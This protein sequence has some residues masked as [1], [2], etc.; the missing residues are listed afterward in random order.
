[1]MLSQWVNETL[2]WDFQIGTGLIEKMNA[3]FQKLTKKARGNTCDT[4]S[5]HHRFPVHIDRKIKIC[6]PFIAPCAGNGRVHKIFGGI[7]D[8]NKRTLAITVFLLLCVVCVAQAFFYYPRLPERVAHHFGAS[9]QPDAWGS[10]EHFLTVYLVVVGLM[11]VMFL[12]FAL[13][14]RKIPGSLMNLPNKQYWLAPERRRETLDYIGSQFLWLGSLTMLLL[15]D[16]FHQSFM[17]HLGK[18]P[19]LG[20]FWITIGVYL[21]LTVVWC[22]VFF[23]KFRKE[24]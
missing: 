6:Q 9:G 21:V 16:V 17:V 2:L 14:L 10:K 11:V 19:G 15:L 20:H 8:M 3:R 5:L 24:K 13:A 22:I 18:A 4:V 12:G 7:E 1:M 23:I